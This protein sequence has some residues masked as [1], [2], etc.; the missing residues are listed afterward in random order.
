MGTPPTGS[1]A[2]GIRSDIIATARVPNP[3][4]TIAACIGQVRSKSVG[5]NAFNRE[6]NRVCGMA[7]RPPAEALYTRYIITE[8]WDISGPAAIAAS[9]N[10]ARARAP[11]RSDYNFSDLAHRCLPNSCG[12]VNREPFV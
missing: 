1:S 2:L 9:K 4:A 8:S 5:K 12:M 11:Y 7:L 10:D 6:T 3:P